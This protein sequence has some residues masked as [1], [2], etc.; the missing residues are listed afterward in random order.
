M[1]KGVKKKN[2]KLRRQIRKTIGALF[3]ASAITVAAIPVQDLGAAP[4]VTEKIKVAVTST[5][6]E[7]QSAEQGYSSVVPYV[8]EATGD[9]KN[10]VIYTSGDG[11]FKFAYI[12]GGTGAV[13]LD[14]NDLGNNPEV[15]IPATLEAYRSYSENY[16]GVEYYCLVSANDELMGY[17]LRDQ[18]LVEESTGRPYYRTTDRSPN[19]I[20]IENIEKITDIRQDDKGFYILYEQTRQKKDENG[21]LVVDKDGKPVYE[22]VEARATC[23]PMLGERIYP[24]YYNQ[25]QIGVQNLKMNYIIILKTGRIKTIIHSGWKQEKISHIGG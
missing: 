7:V 19:G 15:T 5:Q 18:P 12:R 16:Q 17:K 23:E 10:Q 1:K 20:D 14:Y 3:M 25:R 9:T 21:N 6:G 2:R 24:C 13:I 8:A 22:T 11:L 4:N